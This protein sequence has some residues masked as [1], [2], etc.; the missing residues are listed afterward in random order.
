[1]HNNQLLFAATL[2]NSNG[3]DDQGTGTSVANN[4][5]FEEAI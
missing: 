2:Y 5:S 4:V 1:I 3:I